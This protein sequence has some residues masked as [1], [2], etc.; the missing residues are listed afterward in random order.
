MAIRLSSGTLKLT[1]VQFFLSGDVPLIF[2]QSIVISD[3][4]GLK[5][6][7]YGHEIKDK[8][9]HLAAM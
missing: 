1:F 4:N 3:H 7:F 9:M 2:R 8:L 6:I 5:T